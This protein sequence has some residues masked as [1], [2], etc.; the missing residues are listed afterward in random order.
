MAAAAYKVSMRV[1]NSAG[2][3]KTLYLTASDVNA[4]AWVFLSGGTELPLS[5][6]NSVIE[7]VVYSAAGTDTSNVSIWVGGADSGT[8]IINSANLGTVYNRQIQSAP[9]A[10]PAGVPVKFIQNT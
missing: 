9:F 8:R 1:R 5:S 4:A 2:Q 3:V 6:R 10:V 7:D